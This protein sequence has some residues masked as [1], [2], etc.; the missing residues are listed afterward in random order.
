MLH[1][2]C[3]YLYETANTF[4]EFYDNCYCIEKDKQTGKFVVVLIKQRILTPSGIGDL[5][6]KY[7]LY[8]AR[9]YKNVLSAP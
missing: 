5:S 6:S 7:I 4:T 3:E 9:K 1:T 8:E 2:L